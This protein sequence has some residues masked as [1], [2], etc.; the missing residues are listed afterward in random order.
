LLRRAKEQGI[1]FEPGEVFFHGPEKP[2]HFFRLGFSSI[3][4]ERIKPGIEKLVS[5]MEG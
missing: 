3:Q 5:L 4:T 1:L 2:R